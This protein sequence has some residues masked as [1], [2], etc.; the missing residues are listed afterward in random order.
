MKSIKIIIIPLLLI[1]ALLLTTNCLAFSVT[2]DISS[3]GTRV[4]GAAPQNNLVVWI[5]LIIKALFG[6]LGVLFFAL[7]VYGG[8]MYMTSMGK[9]EQIKKAK[10]I[11]I[12]AVIGLAIILLSY[13]IATYIMNLL[14]SS[15]G[16][17]GGDTGDANVQIQ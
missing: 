9:D 6:F 5:A 14:M 13:A 2:G 15:M 8:F 10:N 1:S 3:F 17:G 7:I 12:T 4:Y 11:I 16:G